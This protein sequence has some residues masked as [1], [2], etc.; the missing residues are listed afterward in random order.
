MRLDPASARQV[1]A[2]EPGQSTWLSANAGSGKTRVLTDRVARLLL[3]GCRPERILCLTY[4]KAAAAEMQNRLFRR[5]GEWAMLD[6]ARLTAALVRLGVVP[7]AD[8]AALAQARR[9]FARAIETPG[10]LRIQTIHG[11]C[12]GLLRRFPLEAAVT[13]GF[14]EMDDRTADLLRAEIVELIAEGSEADALAGLAASFTGEHLTGLLRDITANTS[15]FKPAATRDDLLQALGV[16][17]GATLAGLGRAAFG[18]G[19]ADL[20][21][22]M[23]DILANGSKKDAELAGSL[24]SAAGLIP[25]V[26]ALRL[27]E[28]ALLYGEKA[29]EPFGAKIGAIPTKA[30]LAATGGAYSPLAPR[31]EALMRRVEA[32]RSQRI[33]VEAADR[34]F[35]LHRFAAVFLGHYD[36]RKATL[37]YLDFDDLIQR[38]GDLLTDPSIAQ[39][40]LF[41]LDGG[42]DHI[43]IDEAQDTSPA[44]WRVIEQLAQEFLAGEGRTPGGRTIFVVGDKKQSIYSFQGADLRAFDAMRD[45]FRNRLETG[46]G[47]A[48][49]DL[50]YSFRSSP[51]ILR[52]VDLTFDERRG[53][54]LGGTVKHL[55]F[56]DTMPGRVDL[57]APVAKAPTDEP[58]DWFDPV[59]TPPPRHH[60]VVLAEAVAAEIRRMLDAGTIIPR[61][62]GARVLRAGDI[63]ILVQRRSNLF[64]ELIRACKAAGLP[65][66]GADRLRLGGEIAVRDLTALLSFLVT[67]EDDL[68]LATVLRSPLFG[69]SEDALYRLAAGRDGYLWAALRSRPD[70]H[71]DTLRVLV[72]LR[73]RSEFLRPYELLDRALTRHDGRRRLIARLGAEAEDGIEQLLNEAIRYERTAVATLTG[74]LSWLATGEVEVK[75]QIDA[76]SD[77][78]RVMTVHGAKGLEAPVVFLPDCAGRRSPGGPEIVTLE[79]GPALWRTAKDEM[80]DAMAAAVQA[81]RQ[82]M[83]EESQRLLYV[84]MT[85]AESWLIVAAAG[86]TTDPDCWHALVSEGLSAVGGARCDFPTGEGL[87]LSQGDWPETGVLAPAPADRFTPVPE[88][89]LAPPLPPHPAAGLRTP[90]GL[91]GDKTL[92]DAAADPDR[93]APRDEAEAMRRGKLLHLLLEHLPEVAPAER[94]AAAARLLGPDGDPGLVSEA[95]RVLADPA[96]ADL[97]ALPAMTEVAITAPVGGRPLLGVVDRLVVGPDRVIAIDFKSNAAVPPDAE[98]V[99]EGLLRQMGAYRAALGAIYPARQIDVALLWTAR[100]LLMPLPEA[101]TDAALARALSA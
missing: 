20:C 10:G 25:N 14:V 54:D 55:A 61:Q 53:R 36:Q 7:S 100:S 43:L 19:D 90:S 88:W 38:A 64:H 8:G 47:L 71:P 73:D 33:A 46:P 37:G 85:R 62:N 65:I 76:A 74:F 72:D 41:R 30:T 27:L 68:S 97:F 57:W 2:A 52:A 16:P 13:P 99:P 81:D 26:Q 77:Q 75:R 92:A 29:K 96:L 58:A 59:D 12:A 9:L 60:S 93:S 79:D 11:F 44:Q 34:A 70:K 17:R 22:A 49:M 63:L 101:L 28:N 24:R 3:G 4:T 31:F 18:A 1:A 40:V 66:A 51:A 39:W 15:R 5:L 45:H 87:R 95:L 69:W 82:R 21:L 83:A 94:P 35:T 32:S 48:L 86:D 50:E 6:D 80:P 98:A 42:I 91:G 23:A 84:A 78:I 56:H 89:A 67:P